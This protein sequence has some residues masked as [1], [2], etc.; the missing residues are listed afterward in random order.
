M[1]KTKN[2]RKMSRKS[3]TIHANCC[4]HTF[5]GLQRWYENKFEKLGW[6]LLAK[7]YGYNDK[8]VEYK[9]SL[10]RLKQAI[11]HKLTHMKDADKKYDLKI[12]HRNINILIEHANK[13]FK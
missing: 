6:M 2:N 13:D 1:P 10:A 4:E 5:H 7:D 3:K 11:E 8:I 9:S 12:M